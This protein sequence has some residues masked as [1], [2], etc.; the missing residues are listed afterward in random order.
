MITKII[1]K[2]ERISTSSFVAAS[3][4]PFNPH[5]VQCFRGVG[6][7]FCNTQKRRYLNVAL[8]YLQ[9]T[10]FAFCIYHYNIRVKCYKN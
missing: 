8:Q 6:S 3:N 1:S 2:P 7:F 10:I 9:K 5:L 4:G